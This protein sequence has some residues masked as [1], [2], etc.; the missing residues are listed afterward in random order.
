MEEGREMYYRSTPEKI[1]EADERSRIKWSFRC[2]AC[3]HRA[4]LSASY[5]CS[6][7]KKW[8]KGIGCPA[9][10]LDPEF[11]PERPLGIV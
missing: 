7:G 2:A 6:L 3:R 1:A 5:N 9:W 11:D 10:N 8:R 4:P